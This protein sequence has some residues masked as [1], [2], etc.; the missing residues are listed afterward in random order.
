MLRREG[1]LPDY[2]GPQVHFYSRDRL[3]PSVTKINL[4]LHEDGGE[5]YGVMK[6]PISTLLVSIST[7]FQK[8]V[9]CVAYVRNNFSALS[10]R[11]A[12]H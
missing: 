12:V 2:W 3:L 10:S 9:T 7:Y 4:A 8:S 6:F 5:K 11:E 1:A